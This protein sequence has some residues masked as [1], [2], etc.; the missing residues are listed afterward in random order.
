MKPNTEL[1]D[2]AEQ[3]ASLIADENKL[4]TDTTGSCIVK[5]RTD[6]GKF[7]CVM[8]TKSQCTRLSGTWVGADC[9]KKE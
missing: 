4:K 2:I 3:L 5:S 7:Y 8:V 9:P 6:I 1:D